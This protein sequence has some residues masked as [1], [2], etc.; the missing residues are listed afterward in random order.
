MLRAKRVMVD[1][2]KNEY[3]NCSEDD[4]HATTTIKSTK[5]DNEP[6]MVGR[7]LLERN[8]HLANDVTDA[9]SPANM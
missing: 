4:P 1:M 5:G 6:A 7:R 8:V 9:G 2:A 3:S